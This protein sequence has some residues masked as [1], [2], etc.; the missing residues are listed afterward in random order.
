MKI[1]NHGKYISTHDMSIFFR[2][3]ATL[4]SAGIPIINACTMLE[5]SQ[6]QPLVHKLINSIKYDLLS[7]KTL[8]ASLL[9]HPQHID[10]LTH[11]LVHISEHTGK[12]DVMLQ[13]IAQ[14]LEKKLSVSEQIQ[15]ALFYPCIVAGTGVLIT[16]AMLI[17]IVPRFAELFHEIPGN[18]PPLTQAIFT[19][20]TLVKQS[21]WA[22]LFLPILFYIARR[23]RKQPL[24]TRLPIIKRHLLHVQLA[25]FTR[26][27]AITLS[28]G[29]PISNALALAVQPGSDPVFN[30]TIKRLSRH[31][32]SGVQLHRAMR[33]FPC[34]TPL[35]IQMTKTG[36]EAGQLDTMLFKTADM[37]D[38]EI[39][40]LLNRFSQ[41]LEPLIMM[42]L[43]VLIGGLVTGMYLPIFKLGSVI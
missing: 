24:L 38:C 1:F 15:R 32:R 43:G 3:F 35:L 28:A 21:A 2:Q 34:F 22:L 12:L 40:R 9:R 42:I 30:N 33:S 7:G 4:I 19:L 14:H 37:M 36:E 16:L 11:Q 20:A 8:S 5:A 13:N 23:Y 10:A 39:E 17:F 26:N 18:I 6:Q 27:L 41:L 31:V 25:R 29:I